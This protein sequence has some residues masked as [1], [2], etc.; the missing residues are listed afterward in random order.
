MILSLYH[1]TFCF[2]LVGEL[3]NKT[4]AW[5][6]TDRGLRFIAKNVTVKQT[7]TSIT[8][9]N[10]YNEILPNVKILTIRNQTV[11]FIPEDIEKFFPE[12]QGIEIFNS[13]LKVLEQKD[14]KPF[15]KLRELWL[16]QNKLETLSADLFKF[17]TELRMIV[18]NKNRIMS[19]G[20]YILVP[21][22]KLEI[23]NFNNNN[24]IDK[25]A[26]FPHQMHELFI[27][28][29]RNCSP[30]EM[31][32]Q[33][34]VEPV[35]HQP[36]EPAQ[37]EL[38]RAKT[39]IR[40]LRAKLKS[41]EGKLN[42]SDNHLDA[43]IKNLFVASKALESHGNSREEFMSA[44][45]ESQFLDLACYTDIDFICEVD[46]LKIRYNNM[47]VQRVTGAGGQSISLG[48]IT[49]IKI[50]EQQTL[51]LPSNLAEHFKN[52]SKLTVTLSGLFTIRSNVIKGLTKLEILDL[53]HNKIH[54]IPAFAFENLGNLLELDVSF[55]YVESIE[56][57]GLK[58][59]DKLQRLKL[60]NNYLSVLSAK[61]FENLKSLEQLLLQKNDLQIVDGNFLTVLTKLSEADFSKNL[62]I[63][64]RFPDKSLTI[65]KNDI[66]EYCSP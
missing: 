55:N 6:F 53:S 26:G 35:K 38:F 14:L 12:L 45:V 31:L 41:T 33:V 62:C 2:D 25:Y 56:D 52:L 48:S 60:N 66:L 21:L 1:Q 28:I 40:D 24:C 65:I 36:K 20:K 63:D 64:S 4:T 49:E 44:P 54:E 30:P 5:R 10:G 51:F 22:T 16:N 7:Q 23:A 32:I 39:E 37:F 47:K 34:R 27:Q 18:L 29:E 57:D 9:I 8:S 59:L 3:N 17:N 46:D 61:P 58:G 13:S 42:L 15:V 50:V 11:H 19:I 43:A